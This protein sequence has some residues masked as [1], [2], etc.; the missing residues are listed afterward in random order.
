[1]DER[2]DVPAADKRDWTEPPQ[3]AVVMRIASS[4]MALLAS[5]GMSFSAMASSIGVILKEL[6]L[7][8]N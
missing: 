3:L 5:K 2:C 7:L 6:Q 4:K 1:L 8:V